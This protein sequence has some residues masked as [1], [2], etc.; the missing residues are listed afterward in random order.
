MFIPC[1]PKGGGKEIGVMLWD[2]I[3]VRHITGGQISSWLLLY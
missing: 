1:V 2:D 3:A